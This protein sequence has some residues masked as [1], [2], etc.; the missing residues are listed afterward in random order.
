[1]IAGCSTAVVTMCGRILP[2]ASTTPMSAMLFA[3]VPPLVKT[4]SSGE[5]PSSPATC[6]RAPET[7]SAAGAPAQ[8][9][10]EGLP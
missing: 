2:A 9:V 3:S 5:Q 4:T 7:A 1:M 10:L 6:P 8:C